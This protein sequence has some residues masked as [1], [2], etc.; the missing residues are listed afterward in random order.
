MSLAEVR[1]P[2]SCANLGPGFDSF[3]VAVRRHL[4]VRVAERADDRVTTTGDRVTTTGEGARELPTDD[5]NLV[6]RALVAYCEWAGEPVPDVSL[7]VDNAIPL[8][9]GLGSSAA[10]AVAGL[11]LGRALTSG[12]GRDQ[13]MIDLAASFEGHAD[14][15]AAAVLGGLVVVSGG[16]AH[17]LEPADR[18]MPV[19]CVPTDRQATEVARGLLPETVPLAD[20]AANGARAALVLAGLSGAMALHPAAMT[21][22]LHEPAR[23]AAMPG[24]GA[25][26]A[27]L[28]NRRIAACL[29]GAGPTVLAIV[30]AGDQ[31]ALAAVRDLAADQPFAV[32][33]SDWDRAGATTSGR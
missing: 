5:G 14:N 8:E 18:L 27:G 11:A 9:R 4:T 22:V 12:P 24:S 7:A 32:T 33:V 26:V 2:A 30:A 16:R 13:E 21:D 3:A 23:L 19:M 31:D 25:L 20:A 6:W 29:S 17:R 28:R 15:A 1:V 10:A